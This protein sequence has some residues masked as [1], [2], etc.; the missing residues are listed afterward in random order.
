MML[1]GLY[2]MG[3]ALLGDSLKGE[4]L[5]VIIIPLLGISENWIRYR[6]REAEAPDE[7]KE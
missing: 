6:I 1:T 3:N 2:L 7:R 5:L 4:L